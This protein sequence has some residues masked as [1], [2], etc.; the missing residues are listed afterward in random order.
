[1]SV[2]NG[3]RDLQIF[4]EAGELQIYTRM[5]ITNSST[6]AIQVI[7]VGLLDNRM[8]SICHGYILRVNRISCPVSQ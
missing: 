7:R 2:Y 3:I 6:R 5:Q 8:N 1:M 4:E